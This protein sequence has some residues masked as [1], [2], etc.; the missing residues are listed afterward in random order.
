MQKSTSEMLLGILASLSYFTL[1]MFNPGNTVVDKTHLSPVT[2]YAVKKPKTIEKLQK[3]VRES[4]KP[5][6]IAGAR[7]SQG[8]H[9]AYPDALV[10][11]MTKLNNIISFDENQQKVTVQAGIT[12]AQLQQYIDAHNLSLR[13]MQSYNDF[14]VGGGLSVNVHARDLNY[15]PIINTV[16]SIKIVLADGSLVFADRTHN[17][18]LFKA[19]IGGYGLMGIICEAT[20][21]LTENISLERRTQL[22]SIDEYPTLF[23]T[24]YANKAAIF[25]NADL[26]PNKFTETLS[27]TWYITDKPVTIADRLQSR[28]KLYLAERTLEFL[29]R[30]I[31]P[32]KKKRPLVAVKKIAKPEVAWR[33]YEMSYSIKQL[34]MHFHFPTTM[35]L[36]EYFVPVDKLIQ[37]TDL[38][39]TIANKYNVNILNLSIRHV[40]QDTTSVLAYARQESFAL[41]LYLNIL[42]TQEGKDYVCGWTQELMQGILALG[43]TYYLPYLLCA[44]KEQFYAAYPQFNEFMLIKKL[45]DPTN[46]FKNMLWKTYVEE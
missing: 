37:A 26:F 28:E 18:D 17:S 24:I 42:N 20:L 10:I 9:I 13:V 27:T 5:I 7:Y 43:G 14:T 34:A 45:Y 1:Y 4:D 19:A 8:G 12:W 44:T 38:I 6:A 46:K 41:V 21:L 33:N 36:Q 32:L 30:R 29:V 25:H 3:L 2:V 11:D 22:L 16:E 35:T 15:G 39:R 23:K 40:P 31:P